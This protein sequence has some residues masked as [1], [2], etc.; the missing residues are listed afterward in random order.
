ML[1]V[2]FSWISHSLDAFPFLSIRVP[3]PPAGVLFGY[4]L[5]LGLGLLRPRARWQRPV[6]LGM[7]L[8]FS[9]L[10]VFSPFRPRSPDL[11]ITMIDVGQ[12]ESL[13][14]EFPGR[15]TMVIDGGGLA[16]SPFDVGDRVVSPV[17]WRKGITRIDYLVLTHPHPDHLDGLVALA[18]NFRIG[19]FWEG[20]PAADEGIYAA[21]LR[22]LPAQAVRRRCGRGTHA[23]VGLVTV[24]V[25]HPPR[26]GADAGPVPA[27]NENSLVIKMTIAGTS[28]LFMG[29]AGPETERG[30]LRSGIDLESTVLKAGHHG[31]AAS[32]S[33]DFLAAIKPR[34]VLVSVGEGNTYGFPSPAFLARCSASGAEVLRADLDGAVEIRADGRTLAVRTAAPR[35]YGENPDLRL[36]R[37]TKSMIITVD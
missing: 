9:I 25:L 34:L 28:F 7:F 31:S 21:L 13:L 4:Y 29:D 12:G 3:T 10:L 22:S 18:R 37:T 35:A 30:L 36:T 16:A 20:L 23:E 5:T 14:I 33:A 26:A 1:V 17:L 32:T 6:V 19:E 8:V 27:A 15:K 24:D 11:R 2:L